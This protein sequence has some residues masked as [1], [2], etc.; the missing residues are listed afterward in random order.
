MTPPLKRHRPN[1][2]KDGVSQPQHDALRQIEQ[3]IGGRAALQAAL[4]Q[5]P[6]STTLDF[7]IAAIADP[8]QDA[9][10]LST[11]CDEANVSLGE[12]LQAYKV[13]VLAKGTIEAITA[14]ADGAAPVAQDV[15]RRAA[16]YEEPCP[17]CAGTGSNTADPTEAVPN[18]SPVPCD[19][20]QATGALRYLPDL[21]RQ[22]VALELV[23]LLGQKSGST[24]NI[25]QANQTMTAAINGE[26]GAL[27]R[28]QMATDKVLYDN[29]M[30]PDDLGPAD[31]DVTDGEV[32]DGGT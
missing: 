5:A 7:V 14:I 19:T 31:G 24:I 12:L 13:G 32:V 30:T 10:E 15:M 29:P 11:I 28:L 9:R 21:A 23:G 22:K 4:L 8:T 6:P 17:Y 18:P 1:R 27:A 3:A 16:V 2:A 20:C 25:T 26:R